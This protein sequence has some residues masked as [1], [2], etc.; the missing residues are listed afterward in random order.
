MISSYSD[1]WN[2][3]KRLYKLFITFSAANSPDRIA[4]FNEAL[5]HVS[6]AIKIDS[7]IAT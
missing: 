4:A 6:P 7:E 3:K 2:L 5:E 1:D